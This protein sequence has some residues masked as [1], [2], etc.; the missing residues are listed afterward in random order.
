M[1]Y[2]KHVN[3]ACNARNNSLVCGRGPLDVLYYYIILVR[4]GGDRAKEL[5]SRFHASIHTPAI[6]GTER[7]RNPSFPFTRTCVYAYIFPDQAIRDR[8]SGRGSLSRRRRR[9]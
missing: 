1:K 8:G 6:A 3:D 2:P 4:G 7:I 9:G 5:C